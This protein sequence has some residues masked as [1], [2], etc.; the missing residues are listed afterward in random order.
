MRNIW[1]LSSVDQNSAAVKEEL[2]QL[3]VKLSSSESANKDTSRKIIEAETKAAQTLAENQMLAETNTQ[4][5]SKLNEI[6]GQLTTVNV[7]RE[8]SFQQVTS[9]TITNSELTEQLKRASEL[10]LAA[11]GR[12]S[13][14]EKKLHEAILELTQRD[15]ESKS[16]NDKLSALEVEVE[17]YKA[18]VHE[19]TGVEQTL[20]KVKDLESCLEELKSKSDAI[21]N[22]KKG[23]IEANLKLTHELDT[24]QSKVILHLEEELKTHKTNEESLK[25]E[26]EVLKTENHQ[27]SVLQNRIKE[28]EELL[29]TAEAQV[30][31][32]TDDGSKKVVNHE[33]AMKHS[34]EDLEA[35][36]KQVTLS[37]KQI[38]ELEQK[39][40]MSDAKLKEKYF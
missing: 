21:E 1:L 26:I 33:A 20:M 13:E 19:A 4:L 5:E 32:E 29:A 6:E 30:Q 17:T 9:H 34:N 18:Q 7:E 15:S 3:F 24:H 12:I 10:H 14:A 25:A 31:K 2:E 16:L 11:E 38:Q 36:S 27:A 39:L 40:Q 22:E 28:L 23:L 8:T 35:K 37:E